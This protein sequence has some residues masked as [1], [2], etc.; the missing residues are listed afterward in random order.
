[1]EIK[2]LNIDDLIVSE[3]NVRKTLD[4]G[5][6]EDETS[7]NDLANDIRTNGLINP[8]TV[9][10][11]NDKYEII[12]GQRRF[13]ASKIIGSKK[14]PCNIIN[15]TSEKAEILSLVENVQR[16][17]MT[18][19]DKVNIYSKLYNI[20]NKDMDKVIRT[21]NIS[22]TTLKKYLALNE[23]SSDV[24]KLLDVK[25]DDKISLDVAVELTKLPKK[26]DKIEA[27]EKIGDLQNSHKIN[28][29]KKFIKDKSDD[30]EELKNI[31]SEILLQLSKVKLAPSAPYV[32][33]KKG[34]Y[35][36]IPE[37][38]YDDVINLIKKKCGELEYFGKKYE[39][40]EL[41]NSESE[42]K[43]EDEKQK[44]KLK[45]EKS[46]K[47]IEKKKN[48]GTSESSNSESE[49]KEKISKKKLKDFDEKTKVN[50]KSLNKN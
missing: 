45:K 22:K 21:I 38:M 42:S 27:L 10:K 1:M 7:I 33:S 2:E 12:A 19:G 4:D 44:S 50:K 31:Q 15:V 16:N 11:K 14:I 26:I 41:T 28:A 29:L 24:V 5:G 49:S 17:P 9:R 13:L 6:D 37:K 40:S 25:T 20:Y 36:L 30:V 35:I 23:L 47:K 43:S 34:E 8:L 46:S 48:Y 3:L 32:L 39:S 18:Y